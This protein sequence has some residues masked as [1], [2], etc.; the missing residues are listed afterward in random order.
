LSSIFFTEFSTCLDKC[1][2]ELTINLPHT[3]WITTR[4]SLMFW[5]NWI[6]VSVWPLHSLVCAT[7]GYPCD[8]F[9]TFSCVRSHPYAF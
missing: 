5:W 7:S 8:R 4:T 6:S 1:S 9:V 3:S 2:A